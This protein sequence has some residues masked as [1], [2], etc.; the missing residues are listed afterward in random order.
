MLDFSFSIENIGHPIYLNTYIG[1]PI[2]MY[3]VSNM[4]SKGV[5]KV[6]S[7]KKEEKRKDEM[8]SCDKLPPSPI[9]CSEYGNP[10]KWII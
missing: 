2:D 6:H 9:A 8:T 7:S 10:E 5:G 4:N 1:H 3:R